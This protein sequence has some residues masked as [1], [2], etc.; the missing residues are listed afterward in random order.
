MVGFAAPVEKVFEIIGDLRRKDNLHPEDDRALAL[1]MDLIAKEELHKVNF[2]DSKQL[3]GV[4][5]TTEMTDWLRSNLRTTL[6]SGPLRNST[7]KALR[8]SAQA[9]GSG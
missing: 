2:T 8:I 1:T 9:L 6:P 3:Q 7:D 5:L 4:H